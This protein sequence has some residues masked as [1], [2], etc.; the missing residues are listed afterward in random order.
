MVAWPF[1]PAGTAEEA[2]YGQRLLGGAREWLDTMP[3][4]L[5]E[6]KAERSDRVPVALRRWPRA[7]F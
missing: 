6:R 2:R 3:G 1:V 7:A 5:A 4:V